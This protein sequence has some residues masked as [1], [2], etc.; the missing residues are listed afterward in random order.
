[1][2]VALYGGTRARTC[3]MRSVPWHRFR[4][5]L[6]SYEAIAEV[7]GKMKVLDLKDRDTGGGQPC[8]GAVAGRTVRGPAAR[9][10]V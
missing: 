8:R 7:D 3:G 10:Y 6:P 1:M 5:A 2:S 9:A 4:A